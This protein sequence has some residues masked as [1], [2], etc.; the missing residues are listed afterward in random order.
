MTT[1]ALTSPI[2]C[3]AEEEKARMGHAR[4]RARAEHARF[5]REELD[6]RTARLLNGR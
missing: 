2:R 4:F 5:R 1:G 6:A 3:Q